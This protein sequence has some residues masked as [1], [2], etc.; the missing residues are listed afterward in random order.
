MGIWCHGGTQQISLG[1]HQLPSLG[2][3]PQS[4]CPCP[5]APAPESDAGGTAWEEPGRGRS[6]GSVMAKRRGGTE[7]LEWGRGQGAGNPLPACCQ[8]RVRLLRSGAAFPVP[9]LEPRSAPEPSWIAGA[10]PTA[11]GAPPA[12]LPVPAGR[13]GQE[14]NPDPGMQQAVTPWQGPQYLPGSHL[15]PS[16]CSCL[17]TGLPP[18]PATCS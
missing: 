2:W 4:Q 18:C 14:E 12:L 16:S 17:L 7:L 15:L 3:W 13:A 10:F 6:V 8:G 1:G 9:A 5:R 11:A